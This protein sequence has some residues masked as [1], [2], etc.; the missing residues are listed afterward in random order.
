MLAI[1]SPAKDMKVLPLENKAE[2]NYSIPEFF[3]KSAGIISDL[4]KL[5]PKQLSELMKISNK[6]A[7]IN[8]DRY[9][10]WQKEHTIE[11]AAP[12]LLSFSGEAY[13][14]LQAG[15]FNQQQLA[16][17]QNVLRILSGLYGVLRPLDL[18]QEYRLEM[19]TRHHFRGKLKLSDFWYAYLT[20]SIDKAVAASPGE[21]VLI[22]LAS[23]EYASVIDFKKL[24][25]TVVNISFFQEQNGELKMVTVYTKKARGMITRYLIENQ[26]E[27]LEELKA[28]DTEGYCF[29]NKRSSD[30]N[31]VFIR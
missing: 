13:R 2:T 9:R 15:E 20:K 10:N 21:K 31:W 24:K 1:I 19:G 16:Y 12:A 7:L 22:N 5:K 30:K 8:F 26:I 4:K 11:N 28:F 6:L 3:Q 23:N 14:G 18:I 17:S 27:K 25:C 29:D